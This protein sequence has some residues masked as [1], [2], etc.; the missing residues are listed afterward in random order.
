MKFPKWL[1]QFSYRREPVWI[2][3]FA[4]AAPLIGFLFTLIFRLAR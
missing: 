3:A 4:L 2:W 1:H